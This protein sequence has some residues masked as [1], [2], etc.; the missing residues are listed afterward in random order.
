MTNEISGL[1]LLEFVP[2][3]ACMNNVI[4]VIIKRLRTL[5]CTLLMQTYSIEYQYFVEVKKS[6][7]QI[8]A[9]FFIDLHVNQNVLGVNP[10]YI[11]TS[12]STL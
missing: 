7:A 6:K 9:N 2:K 4:T 10:L 1:T 5:C 12:N 8:Q 11:I 3:P